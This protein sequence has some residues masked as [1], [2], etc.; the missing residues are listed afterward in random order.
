[1]KILTGKNQPKNVLKVHTNENVC[2]SEQ[3]QVF[4]IKLNFLYL[5][6]KF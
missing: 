2:S 1:M 5:K 3:T 4:E 6:T